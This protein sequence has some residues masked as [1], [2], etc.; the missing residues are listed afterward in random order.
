MTKAEMNPLLVRSNARLFIG[1]SIAPLSILS[2]VLI[3]AAYPNPLFAIFPTPTLIIGAA[4]IALEL[5]NRIEKRDAIV[6]RPGA[7]PEN[8]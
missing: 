5:R 1:M 6:E 3:L 2:I 4:M 8:Y 7:A